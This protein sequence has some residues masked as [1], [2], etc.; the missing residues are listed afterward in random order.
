M[1]QEAVA[2]ASSYLQVRLKEGKNPYD[3]LTKIGRFNHYIVDPLFRWHGRNER[4][5]A[6]KS[7]GRVS[8]QGENH[9]VLNGGSHNY[10][11]LYE[12]SPK[13]EQLQRK[14]LDH[15]P[16]ADAEAVPLL[17]QRM[18]DGLTRFFNA[19]CCYTTTTGYQS[20]VLGIPAIARDNSLIVMDE[21]CHN[22]IFTASYMSRAGARKRFRHNDMAH[23]Q[24]ILD[25]TQGKQS[26]II[27]VVEGLYSM[28]GTIPPLDR[29]YFLKK[30]F[31]FT[32]YADEA[33]S[34][35]SMEKTGGGC[36]EMWND[37]HPEALVPD[38]VIDVRS[39]VLSKAVGGLGGF[40]CAAAPSPVDMRELQRE[41][42]EAHADLSRV[43]QQQIEKPVAT[44]CSG[45][46]AAEIAA[47]HAARQVYGL[48]SGSSRWILGTFPQH[49]EVEELTAQLTR[50]PAALTYPD[51][52]LGLMS[53]IAGLCRP[54]MACR[55][56]YFLV[57]ANLPSNAE[58]GF[59]VASKN[60][61]T[62]CLKYADRD[63][64]VPLF[65]ALSGRSA[66]YLTLYLDPVADGGYMDLMALA[67]QLAAK[68]GA[69]QGMTVLLNDTNGLGRLGPSQLGIA[70]A[71]NLILFSQIL[72]ARI[73]VCG[74][75]YR[76]FSL[77]G[78]YLAGDP[79]IIEELRYTS[80]CYMFS[81]SPQPF[82]M[83]MVK[84]A[85]HGRL[86][87]APVEERHTIAI[88]TKSRLEGVLSMLRRT[89]RRLPQE[90]APL[91]ALFLVFL[92]VLF[93]MV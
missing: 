59:R 15:L 61:E 4:I 16:F 58:E 52:D 1:L 81:T 69:N 73:L 33:H 72:S 17:N 11:G 67:T 63:A 7:L 62:V 28:D 70:S 35:G 80:R 26:D 13:D 37:Q 56:H 34:F 77:P 68:K 78:G 88:A 85:L 53:T 66:T 83:A 5:V 6:S 19:D 46:S 12:L 84:E 8:M 27:V 71:V 76:A 18:V 14:C 45:I 49:L 41:A 42:Q 36:L 74:S 79:T 90:W 48:G 30:I 86:S 29:L 89:V 47:G 91:L 51:S 38:D 21:K 64:L 9:S 44:Q 31:N 22:S 55:R 32:L 40:V 87:A 10:A 82:V 3:P 50:Q 2:F 93:K 43:L 23:L 75:F 92:H 65:E 20:N 25:S 60:S 39:A 24:S 57:P 54:V